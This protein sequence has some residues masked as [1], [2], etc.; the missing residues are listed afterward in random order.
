M[1]PS[2]MPLLVTELSRERVVLWFLGLILGD[3]GGR[4]NVLGGDSISYCN[5]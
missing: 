2:R 3:S 4:V 5:E 1:L